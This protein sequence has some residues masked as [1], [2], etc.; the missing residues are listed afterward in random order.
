MPA[1][2]TALCTCIARGRS[3]S[4]GP[5]ASWKPCAGAHSDSVQYAARSLDL[6]AIWRGKL[7]SIC[8]TYVDGSDFSVQP[9]PPAGLEF[10]IICAHGGA[11]WVSASCRRLSSKWYGSGIRNSQVGV[12]TFF[13]SSVDTGAFA[14]SCD[15]VLKVFGW[16]K[17]SELD[18]LV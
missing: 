15:Y 9:R 11:L 8:R 2:I 7:R 16:W 3:V 6:V 12:G 5:H 14:P 10:A 17:R 1:A 4:L 18:H 13:Y